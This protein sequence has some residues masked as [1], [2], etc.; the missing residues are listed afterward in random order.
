[1]PMTRLTSVHGSFGAHVIAARLVD[2]GFD[3]ELHGA[4][5]S[6]YAVTVGDLSVV[7]VYVPEDQVD[8]ASY[9][10]LVTEVEAALDDDGPHR[11]HVPLALRLTAA[12]LLATAV[13]QL[14]RVLL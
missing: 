11:R 2:E 8:E 14:A 6:P 9:V 12:A 4:V 7:D 5:D 1:M 10:L 3:V 13:L